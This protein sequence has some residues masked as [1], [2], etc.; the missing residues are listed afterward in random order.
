[1]LTICDIN[2]YVQASYNQRRKNIL[3]LTYGV[4]IRRNII[5]FNINQRCV[6]ETY[7]N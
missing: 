4:Y 5:S 1:M 6:V 3:L 7:I 2:N